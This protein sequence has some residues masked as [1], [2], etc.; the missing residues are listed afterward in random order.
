MLCFPLDGELVLLLENPVRL[1]VDGVFTSV[2]VVSSSV[3]CCFIFVSSLSSPD[4]GS[5]SSAKSGISFGYLTGFPSLPTALPSGSTI[6]FL[7]LLAQM[8]FPYSPFEQPSESETIVPHHRNH[9]NLLYKSTRVDF[10]KGVPGELP[11]TAIFSLAS[12]DVDS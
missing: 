9:R 4:S 7:P 5:D 6:A 3:A 1:F 8:A 10:S 2:V 11:T 12:L